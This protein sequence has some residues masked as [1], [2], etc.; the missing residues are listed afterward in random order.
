MGSR[1]SVVITGVGVVSP[2]GIGHAAYWN[3][4]SHQRSGVGR[5]ESAALADLPLGIGAAVKDFDGKAY[6]KPRKALKV[7]SREIQT[8]FSAANL[9]VEHA[10]LEA[11]H[12]PPDRTGV[13]FG[14]EMLYCEP[15]EML[16][17]YRRCIDDGTFHFERWG[18]HF[19]SE[20]YPLWMLMYLPNMIACHIGIAHDARGPN[21]TI[22][23]GEVSSL[24]ALIEAA[25]MIERGQADIMLSGGSSSRLGITPMLY[26]GVDRLSR[27]IDTPETACRPFDATRDGTINGEGAAAFVLEREEFAAARGATILARIVGWGMACGAKNSSA[28]PHGQAIERSLEQGLAMSGLSPGD[29]GHVNA[30]AGGSV[31]DDPLEAQA[32]CAVLGDVPVTA[33]KSYFGNLGSSGG[34]VEMAASVLGL[35]H[36][37]I[38]ATLNYSVP[39]PACPV[40]VVAGQTRQATQ[41]SAALLNQSSTGQAVCV[42]LAGA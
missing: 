6:V 31:E 8:G 20:M 16:A 23:Q 12:I 39:D 17:V 13:V 37:L 18:T 33:P 11:G 21:N 10:G 3:S 28:F 42:V 36:G 5:L 14:S 40:N 2:I 38:P 19:A 32:I 4:M 1:S 15:E 9:A 7:M 27:R 24:L 22:C 41:P 35:H 34:A 26:R 30:H 29:V 25:G